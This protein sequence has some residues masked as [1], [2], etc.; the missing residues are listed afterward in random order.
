[1]VPAGTVTVWL[2]LLSPA[3]GVVKP[4]WAT[5]EGPCPPLFLALTTDVN[6]PLVQPARSA[7]KSPFVTAV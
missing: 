2:R 3:T 4:T 7:S 1:M 6:P 5:L